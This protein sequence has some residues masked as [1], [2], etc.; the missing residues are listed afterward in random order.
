MKQKN[1]V[2]GLML[3]AGGAALFSQSAIASSDMGNCPWSAAGCLISSPPVLDI[4]NDTRDNLIR[5]LGEKKAFALPVLPDSVDAVHSRDYYF[6]PHIS[7]W[8]AHLQD[9][10]PET[11]SVADLPLTMQAGQIGVDDALLDTFRQQSRGLEDRHVSNSLASVEQFYRALL[12]ETALT[13]EQRRSLATTRLKV[14]G[15]AEAQAEIAA[16]AFPE[17]SAA[18]QFQHYLLAANQFYAGDYPAAAAAFAALGG[19]QQPWLAET[20]AYMLM[21]T[22]LNRSSANASGM[23]GDFDVKNIDKAAAT[24]AR[25]QAQAYLQKWPE[26]LYASS[27]RGMLRRINWYLEDWDPLAQQAEQAL[28]QAGSVG[29]LTSLIAET[30]DKLLSKDL[31]RN[32]AWFLSAPDAPLLTFIQT[33]RLMRST[34]CDGKTPCVDSPYLEQIK[35]I[36][37]KGQQLPLW[38]YLTLLLAEQKQDYATVLGA[39]KPA[40]SL[41]EHDILTFSNQ[42]LYGDV[43]MDQ[44]NWDA[45]RQHWLHL[46][47]L[48]KDKEQQQMLQ[49]MLA[50]TLVSSGQTGKIFASDSQVTNLRYRSLVLKKL[51]TPDLLRQQVKEGSG[52]EEKTI[53]LHTLLVKDLIAGRYGHW[54]QDKTLANHIAQPVVDSAFADVDLTV[55]DWAGDKAEPG[56][57]CASLEQTVNTLNARADDAHALNCLGEF[58]RTTRVKVDSWPEDDGNL[59]L[60]AVV[61][62][63][64][65]GAPNRQAYYTQVI[66]DP[67]AEPEDKSFALYRAVMCYAPSGYNDCGGKEVEPAVRKGWFNRLKA[68]YRGGPWA[69]RLKYY[70]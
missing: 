35:P 25:Q 64:S 26:G 13:A 12:A 23:Y 24:E 7:E 49:A 22:D 11:A 56:Y 17:N 41:P 69:Q 19:S 52:N 14:N 63:G 54:L 57:R 61:G 8:Y 15:S 60:G 45:A 6:A 46:L 9:E 33:L 47:T 51:A 48:T 27:A 5:L 31:T 30:D 67:R 70:W 53:A 42:V 16:L 38:Q 4:G 28:K 58:F 65:D 18:A 20:A 34:E 29:E 66:Q 2:M 37:E 68:D 10:T 3:A 59:A 1:R 39:I 36:F 44:K 32:E 40:A 55:F 50:A 43:L 62:D 21:R